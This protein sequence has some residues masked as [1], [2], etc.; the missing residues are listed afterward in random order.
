MLSKVETL[1]LIKSIGQRGARLDSDIQT[2]AISSVYYSVCYG[3]ITIGQRLVES[4]SA[5]TRKAALVGFL[6]EFG[7]FMAK[8]KTVAYHKNETSVSY[9]EN[10]EEHSFLLSDCLEEPELSERYCSLI[11]KH[12]TA[13]K[14]EKIASKYDI[15]S[16]VKSLIKRMEKEIKAGNA[17]HTEVYDFISKAYNDYQESLEDEMEEEEEDYSVSDLTSDE[18]TAEIAE[19]I[20]KAA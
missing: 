10:E 6:E 17:V 1:K 5:G 2:A 9:V 3:D 18:V 8:E 20:Q 4:V 19:L 11:D 15:D 14:P 16:A 13:F 12:W 7:H